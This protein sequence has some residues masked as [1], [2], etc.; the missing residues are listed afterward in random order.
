MPK[1]LISQLR[2]NMEKIQPTTNRLTIYAVSILE[3]VHLSFRNLSLVHLKDIL[4]ALDREVADEQTYRME[5][6][7]HKVR[8]ATSSPTNILH[9]L[10]KYIECNIKYCLSIA[11]LYATL[12]ISYGDLGYSYRSM[13]NNQ[14]TDTHTLNIP[15]YQYS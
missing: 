9:S 7:F 1:F 6:Q 8:L 2:E 11:F 4:H 5:P 14:N 12:N 15:Q 10:I 13:V 3:R